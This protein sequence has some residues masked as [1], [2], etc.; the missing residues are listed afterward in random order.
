MKLL[1]ILCFLIISVN[2]LSCDKQQVT[3]FDGIKNGNETQIDC[4]GDCE[5]SCMQNQFFIPCK[6]NAPNNKLRVSLSDYSLNYVSTGMIGSDYELVRMNNTTEIS[7]TILIRVIFYGM[8]P[9]QNRS[10]DAI[11]SGGPPNDPADVALQIIFGGNQHFPLGKVY[12][13]YNNGNYTCYL[14]GIYDSPY[15]F[16]SKFSSQ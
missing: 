16:T 3:C 6:S 7:S 5:S 14:C 10:F 9:T 11:G 4:G 13:E 1:R 8:P 15:T 2:L 12:Y